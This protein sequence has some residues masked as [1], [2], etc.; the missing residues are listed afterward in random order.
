MRFPSQIQVVPTNGSQMNSYIVMTGSLPP[1][2]CGV[3]DYSEALI[4][5][6]LSEGLSV[7]TYYA[8]DWSLSTIFR[9]LSRLR[10]YGSGVLNIQYP[11]QGY[12][13]SVV[14]VL[15]CLLIKPRISVV[16]LHEFSRRSF[17]AKCASYFF[18]LFANWFIFTTSFERDFCCTI[19]PWI[20][21]RCSVIPLASNIPMRDGAV[22]DLDIS[23]F[24]HIRPDKGIEEFIAIVESIRLKS[25]SNV[26]V[27][28][29]LVD[30]FEEYAEKLIAQLKVVG[31]SIVLNRS[32]D[33]VSQLL[34]R[35]KVALLPFPDGVTLRRGTALAAMGNGALLV[36]RTAPAGS[37]EFDQ[38]Y[39]AMPTNGNI[40]QVLLH[41]LE[42]FNDYDAV[43]L[44]GQTFARSFSWKAIAYAYSHVLKKVD[45]D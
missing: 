1:D 30:G 42:H 6:L 24:G 36:T 34:S 3:G 39:I 35:T 31:A 20:A 9:H 25:T 15:L 19:A 29:Q 5:S 43:R 38:T 45:A 14:P 10:R 28:G 22:R 21:S 18:F 44:T 7:E 23:Y 27:I 4:Q 2:V 41:V 40:E 8:N 16:T 12:G 32:A 11:T 13:W 17:K 26:N 37:P 33:E